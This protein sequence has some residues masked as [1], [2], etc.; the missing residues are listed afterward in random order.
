[1]VCIAGFL[2]NSM[3]AVPLYPRTDQRIYTVRGDNS[4]PPFEY[5]DADGKAAG[6]NVDILNAISSEMNMKFRISLGTWK[7]VRRDLEN[8]RIDMLMGMYD[9]PGRAGKV[10]FAMPHFIMSYSLFVRDDSGITGLDK[11]KPRTILVQSGDVGED[12]L[13]ERG[14]GSRL[15][16]RSSWI[17]VM[18]SLS[19][20][21]ADSA[22]VSRL[23]G[24][25]YIK[26]NKITGIRDAGASVM[27]VKYCVAVRKGDAEL[28]GLVNEG[29]GIIKTKGIY[30]NIHEKWFGV[31]IGRE[32]NTADL[33][34]YLLWVITVLAFA[35]LAGFFWSWSL[36]AQVRQKTAF[37]R[38]ELEE[39]KVIEDALRESERKYQA[40]VEKSGQVIFDYDIAT[41]KILWAGAILRVTGYPEREFA[42]VT[43]NRLSEYI[44]PD[45]RDGA[46]AELYNARS[47][48]E[49]YEKQIRFRHK[50]GEYLFFDFRGFFLPD[51]GGRAVRMLG[52]I[53][54]V[55]EHTVARK[56]I[57]RKTA[58]LETANTKL[59]QTLEELYAS[60]EE[61]EAMNAELVRSQDEIT[62]VNMRLAESERRMTTL[63]GN[64][65]GMVYRRRFTGTEGR[66]EYISRGSLE[67]SGY[68]PEELE[69][70]DRVRFYDLMHED[71][72]DILAARYAE[73]VS[74]R[75]FY[76]ARYR[77][78][79]REGE[80]RWVWDKCVVVQR[81]DTGFVIEGFISD[82][83]EL[84]R[85]DLQLKQVQ[86]LEIIGTLAGGIAHDFNN[87]LGGIKGSLSLLDRI[88]ER[89]NFSEKTNAARYTTIMQQASDRAIQLVRQLLTL[90]RKDEPAFTDVDLR[91]TIANTINICGN[92]F[93]REI[94]IEFNPPPDPFIVRAD[95]LQ[96]E[97]VMLNLCVNASHAM[98]I[99]RPR[100]EAQGGTLGIT[101]DVVHADVRFRTLHPLAGESEYYALIA[102]SDTGVGMS[103]DVMQ[104]LFDPFFTTK[105]KEYGSGLGLPIVYSIITSH[106]GF[107]ETESEAGRGSVFNVYIPMAGSNIESGSGVEN[108][109]YPGKGSGTV[110]VID[111]EE[112]IRTVACGMLEEYGFQVIT[113]DNGEEGVE[114]FKLHHDGICAVILDISMPV[115]SGEE[116]YKHMKAYDPSVPV[117]LTSGLRHDER[118]KEAMSLG[119]DGFI[120][121]PYGA[122]ELVSMLLALLEK[123]NRN[124][125]YH[126]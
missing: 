75:Q 100:G 56:E 59:K 121:K 49:K 80:I 99:M 94:G 124:G 102:V 93:P 33:L 26:K 20:K 32:R 41:G 24:I 105:S 106:G 109:L 95:P 63:L 79:N 46:M 52:T 97:Q 123:R 87:L 101:L 1:M 37:L 27:Q 8:G 89:E 40:V 66:M 114:K 38:R 96:M 69:K 34:K 48:M 29:L 19:G 103:H 35:A 74:D 3:V 54:D 83:T 61:L 7:D 116:A 81:D 47:R 5:I 104:H 45:D 14:Y 113:A 111:D 86:K 28:L 2:L 67:I 55:T 77:I 98:T 36:R 4:Y 25:I 88:L 11:I 76:D 50:S 122:E 15:V 57:E 117:L 9:T 58:E 44:H 22:F 21:E 107:I 64:I 43:I 30:D 60:N 65:P 91:D 31:Y 13:E 78:V 84:E 6:F 53:V 82:M 68:A 10:D 108:R 110:L 118:V 126:E 62:Q 39:R 51:A 125:R 12:Y 112:I 120:Q 85:K 16:R 72:R 92:S 70:E 17:G 90:S 42:D 23:Q 18:D 119:V 73:L 71:D 115:M